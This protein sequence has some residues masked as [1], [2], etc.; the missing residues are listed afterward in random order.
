MDERTQADTAAPTLGAAEGAARGPRIDADGSSP[1]S[2]SGK[3]SSRPRKARK[4]RVRSPHPGVKLRAPRAKQKAWRAVYREPDTGRD[5]YV[6]LDP[7]VLGSEEARVAWAKMKSRELARVKVD[8]AAGVRPADAPETVAAAIALYLES[9]KGDA[10]AH[11][12]SGYARSL[13]R[14]QKWAT[15]ERIAT[16]AQLT[17]AALAR[18]RDAMVKLP[19]MNAVKGGKR[20]ARKASADRR[21]PVSINADLTGVKVWLTALR[22]RGL[23][24]HLHSDSIADSLRAVKVPR[25]APEFYSSAQL[26]RI[27]AAALRHDADCFAA[28]REEHAGEREPGSTV[29]YQPIAPFAAFVLLTGMRRSEALACTWRM[30]DLDTCD[31][32]GARV[33]EIRLPASVTK[34]RRA[35]TIGLEVS[36]AVRRILASMRIGSGASAGAV[37]DGYTGDSVEAA[38]QRLIAEYGAPAFTWQ[39]LRSTCSTALTNAPGIFGAASAWLSAKQLGHSVTIAERHYAGAVR[40]LPRAARTIEAALRIE[41]ELAAVLNT[42]GGAARP[43]AAKPA[44]KRM[45][46]RRA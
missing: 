25:E 7:L 16:V 34:T 45:R 27:F 33:G 1:E 24:P 35:R 3:A 28:T 13:A 38:R 39:G 19:R 2:A 32:S 21:G 17:P 36:P 22:R 5:V 26:A 29:R 42:I 23:V 41:G 11:T 9:R 8:R 15:G 6:T 44:R 4:R 12:V 46:L 10:S 30:L 43:P 20:G 37:F 31:A 14:L 18:F 40:D